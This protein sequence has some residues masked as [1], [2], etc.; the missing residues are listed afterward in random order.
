M[1][2]IL[3][4]C[5]GNICRSPL[6]E[7]IFQKMIIKNGLEK[8]LSTDSAG[9]STYHIGD[10]P[11]PRSVDVATKHGVPIAHKGRQVACSDKKDF[12]YIMA[13]D[14]SNYRNIISMLGEKPEGLYIMRDF[15]DVDT[16]A[17]V[18]DP[19]YGG[20][21]GFENVYQMLERSCENLLNHI[22]KEHNL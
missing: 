6:A 1:I 10:D 19:Y 22:R 21:D 13:M 15:D 16:G 18:P 4:V 5:L 11:D 3:F 20:R 17:D 12:Q 7:A 14:Q 8:H 2:K 9:T